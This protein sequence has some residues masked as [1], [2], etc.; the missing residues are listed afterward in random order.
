MSENS[1][2]YGWCKKGNYLITVR[3]YLKTEDGDWKKP[4]KFDERCSRCRYWA[5]Y[6]DN[7]KDFWCKHQKEYMQK[8]HPSTRFSERE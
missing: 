4:T 5:D 2:F 1:S 3:K 7:D 6:Y 8:F